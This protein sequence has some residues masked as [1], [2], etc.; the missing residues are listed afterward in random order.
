[1]LL[2]ALNAAIGM[3]VLWITDAAHAYAPWETDS[4]LEVMP[5]NA[6]YGC[7]ILG[8][9]HAYALSRFR[10]NH[11]ELQQALGMTV[12]NMGLPAAGG[13]RPARLFF[14]EFLAR[15]NRAENLVYFVEPFVFFAP[16]ANDNHKFVHYEPA[17]P[18]FL[19]RLVK[20]GYPWRRIFAYVRSKFEAP[21]LLQKPEV[22][23]AHDA[24][25]TPPIDPVRV[26]A[27][28]DSLYWEGMEP[29]AFRRYAPDLR[30]IVAEAHDAGMRVYL[31][32]PPT[33][34]GHEPGR[35]MLEDYVNSLRKDFPLTW[36][37][38]TSAMPIPQYFYD[39][40]HLNTAGVGHFANTLLAPLL[41][42]EDAR[43]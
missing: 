28:L 39:L 41:H 32:A 23:I 42:N 9:S 38:F 13:V 30:R 22:M 29:A 31:I 16:D 21:W 6:E 17:R 11:R 20:D 3:G 12:F 8:T 36:R 35:A 18:G 27:R 40:D 25:V 24:V 15:G 2:L 26:S 33:L 10:E 14:E 4:I 7:V 37:D 1:M 19:W 43:P 34:L 5:R